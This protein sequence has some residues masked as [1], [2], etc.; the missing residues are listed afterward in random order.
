MK[1]HLITLMACAGLFM[2]ACSNSDTEDIHGGN[3]D[4]VKKPTVNISLTRSESEVVNSLN[5]FAFDLFKTF[6]K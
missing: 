6:E 4:P 2:T 1:K 3:N 5:E